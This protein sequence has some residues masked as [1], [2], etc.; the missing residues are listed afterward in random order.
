MT[1]TN[2]TIQQTIIEY[3]LPRKINLG[4]VIYTIEET[5]KKY[6]Y[7]PC[8][9][10]EGKGKLTVNGITFSCPCCRDYRSPFSIA[11]YKVTRWRVYEIAQMVSTGYWKASDN[12]TLIIKVY[13]TTSRGYGNTKDKRLTEYNFKHSRNVDADRL[14]EA[15][16]SQYQKIDDFIFDCYGIACEAADKLNEFEEKKVIQHNK[17]NGTNYELP[18]KPK[19]DARSN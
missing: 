17:E 8:K 5:D 6:Y 14:I 7:E 9:V 11:R 1:Q 15:S 4:D 13:T 3:N 10:C 12:K 19:Y 18:P 16:K 2:Q